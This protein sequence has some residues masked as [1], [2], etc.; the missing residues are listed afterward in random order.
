MIQM[1]APRV[2]PWKAPAIAA[3]GH[4]NAPEIAASSE[5]AENT[6]QH[7]AHLVLND[8]EAAHSVLLFRGTLP[9]TRGRGA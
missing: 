4:L 9:P 2:L 6:C 7:A 5:V 3:R 1:L 8:S